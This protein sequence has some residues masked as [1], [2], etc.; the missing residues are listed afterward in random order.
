MT[1]TFA[2]LVKAACLSKNQ[3]QDMI[4]QAEIGIILDF[5]KNLFFRMSQTYKGHISINATA[6]SFVPHYSW[7]A[8]N[9]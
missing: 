9:K 2:G 4:N 6:V 5:T 3:T 8:E 1:V 7:Y